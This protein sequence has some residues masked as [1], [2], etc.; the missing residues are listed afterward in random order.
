LKE[1]SDNALYDAKRSGR[2]RVHVYPG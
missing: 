2:D 1:L